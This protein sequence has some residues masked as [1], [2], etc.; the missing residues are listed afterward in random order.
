MAHDQPARLNA[1]LAQLQG[2]EIFLHIDKDVNLRKYISAINPIYL[3]NVLVL[4]DAERSRGTWGGYSLVNI[5]LQL[6]KKFVTES[7]D[8][9]PIVFLSGQDFPIKPVAE[10]VNYLKTKSDFVSLKEIDFEKWNRGDTLEVSR[11]NRVRNMHFREIRIFRKCKN[12]QSLRYKI[13]SVPNWILSNLRLP[14]LSFNPTSAYY[15]GS[16]WI[17]LS[18]ESCRAIILRERDLRNEFRFTFCPDEIAI[19]TLL[20]RLNLVGRETFKAKIGKFDP[21]IDADFHLIH[22]SLNYAWNLS[23]LK[24]IRESEKYFIRKPS[25]ELLDFLFI[26]LNTST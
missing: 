21:I 23:D 11:I 3:K 20:A 12:R 24:V 5:M 25:G 14:N 18:K 17:G 4:Q 10:F 13:G 9:G 26:D 19:Q 2:Y 1:L 16:Q 8:D 22:P 6:I 7:K 15:L